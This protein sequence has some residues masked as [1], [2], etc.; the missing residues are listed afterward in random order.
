MRRAADGRCCGFRLHRSDVRRRLV[1]TATSY[2]QLHVQRAVVCQVGDN[3][4]TV[5]DLN[6]VIQLNIGSSHNTRA[7]LSQGQRHFITTVQLDG[8]TFQVQQD[9]DYIFLHTFDRRVLVEY[10]VDL[11]LD[12]CAARHGG[13]QDATQRVAQGVTKT[14]L[15]RLERDL[16]AGLTDHLHIDVAGGQ[17]LIYR[18]LHGCT[19]FLAL[20]WSR[21]R[22]SGFR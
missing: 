17:E 7:L 18:T 11:G 13:Q 8:Q 22:Q 9:L 15:E 3:V 19:Y 1:A 5:D 12:H 20:T 14:T 2:L 6:I 21:A 4:V 10:A 16:G